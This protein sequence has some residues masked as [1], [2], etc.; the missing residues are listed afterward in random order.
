MFGS[1]GDWFLRGSGDATNVA[2]DECSVGR[3]LALRAWSRT[4]RTFS[5]RLLDWS[6]RGGGD[7]SGRSTGT[8]TVHVQLSYEDK[9][10]IEKRKKYRYIHTPV[11]SAMD[12][13][14]QIRKA[15]A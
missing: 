11:P 12:S 2:C 9:Q 10:K 3:E 1:N 4:Q 13:V 14:S 5:S 8:G 15:L 7:G 6:F